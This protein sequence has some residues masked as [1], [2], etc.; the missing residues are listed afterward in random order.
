V[1]VDD[2]EWA[3]ITV[4]ADICRGFVERCRQTTGYGW[5]QRLSEK[6][7]LWFSKR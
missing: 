7:L 6:P 5:K 1:T 2:L 4:Y 3:N